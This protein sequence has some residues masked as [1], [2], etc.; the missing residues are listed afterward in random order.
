MKPTTWFMILSVALIPPAAA[1]QQTAVQGKV[2]FNGNVTVGAI[3]GPAPSIASVL[4][5]SGSVGTLVTITGT[6]LGATQ[7]NSTVLFA[8]VPGTPG[9]W[10]ATSFVV[11]V[12]SG[13]FTG[14]LTISINGSTA[15]VAFT[16]DPVVTGLSAIVGGTLTIYGAGF[17]AAQGTS[18]VTID[19]TQVT[20][21][22]GGWSNTSITVNVPSGLGAG[23]HSVVVTRAGDPATNPLS[24]FVSSVG[25]GG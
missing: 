22:S 13:A 21:A 12:P 6:N 16:V 1:A 5:T 24:F 2:Q 4:P 11:A 7:G 10:S 9:A 23:T 17:G 25:C 14:P 19:G 8:G 3:T 18:T 20:V 15:G